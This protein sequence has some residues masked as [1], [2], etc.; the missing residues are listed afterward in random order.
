MLSLVLPFIVVLVA[1]I[2]H[3]TYNIFEDEYD[4][5]TLMLKNLSDRIASEIEQT[6]KRGVLVSRTMSAAQE[7]GMFG[8]SERS[9][10]FAHKILIDFPEFTGS[11]FA[12]TSSE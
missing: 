1:T 2:W 11:Y 5:H 12:C 3:M 7:N 8:D 9:L 10:A 6:Y 4:D